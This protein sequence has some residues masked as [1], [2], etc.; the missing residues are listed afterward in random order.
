[1]KI[2]NEENRVELIGTY[3]GHNITAM[4]DEFGMEYYCDDDFMNPFASIEDVKKVID[5]SN[6]QRLVAE[7]KKTFYQ[8][9]NLKKK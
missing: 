2:L 9:D 8:R 5:N 4:E 1:M 6:A 7:N 3:R